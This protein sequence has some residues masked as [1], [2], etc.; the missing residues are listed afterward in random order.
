MNTAPYSDM[1]A[2]NGLTVQQGHVNYCAEHGHAEHI[3]N[4]SLQSMCP[5]CGDD[6]GEI[7]AVIGAYILGITERLESLSDACHGMPRR[8]CDALER[9]L[10]DLQDIVEN[11]IVRHDLEKFLP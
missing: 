4:G 9:E 2:L 8:A 11:F 3:V 7:R 1:A 6:I 10:S 5:R